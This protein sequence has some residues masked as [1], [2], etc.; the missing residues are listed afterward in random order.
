MYKRQVLGS[1]GGALGVARHLGGATGELLANFASSAFISGMDLGV[2]V[3]AG[4]AVAGAVLALLAIPSRTAS[5]NE[6]H[7]DERA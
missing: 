3:A 7:P 5:A 2:L 6:S 4:V 1:L